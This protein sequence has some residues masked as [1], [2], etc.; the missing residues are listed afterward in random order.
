[1]RGARPSQPERTSVRESEPEIARKIARRSERQIEITV[2]RTRRRVAAPPFRRLIDVL[3][4][5]L[6]LTG[7]K[8]G[9][10]E[11]ECGACTVLIDGTPVNSCL[12]PVCQVEGQTI[13]HLHAWDA[14]DRHRLDRT[15]G[16][17]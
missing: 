16:L 8:E 4:E 14:D 9:C 10:G 2:N 1:M 11:G 15:G 12:I 6:G 5:D 17:R 13:R 3:R 7:T